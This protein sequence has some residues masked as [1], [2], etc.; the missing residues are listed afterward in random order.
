MQIRNEHE[1]H[2]SWRAKEGVWGEGG[3]SAYLWL[4]LRVAALFRKLEI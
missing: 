1:N 2:N 4:V 3:A